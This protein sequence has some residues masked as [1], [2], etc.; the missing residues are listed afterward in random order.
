MLRFVRIRCAC[1]GRMGM[2][3]RA[4]HRSRKFLQF[5]EFHVFGILMRTVGGGDVWQWCAPG[6][7]NPGWIFCRI[8][9]YCPHGARWGRME[10][11]G[12]TG[13][14]LR[15]PLFLLDCMD[16]VFLCSI[17]TAQVVGNRTV[18]Q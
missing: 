3:G 16:L 18:Q 8:F 4:V 9:P 1:A 11:R 15:A 7:D 10:F 2:P 14:R 13:T 12:L 17:G 5:L 6:V